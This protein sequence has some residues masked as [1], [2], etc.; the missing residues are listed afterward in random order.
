MKEE[1][2]LNEE[3]ALNNNLDDSTLKL[4]EEIT[5]HHQKPKIPERKKPKRTDK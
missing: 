4:N 1:E 5:E 2:K 3:A